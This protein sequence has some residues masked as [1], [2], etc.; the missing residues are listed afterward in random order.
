[1]PKLIDKVREQ[2]NSVLDALALSA[3]GV[4]VSFSTDTKQATVRV[5]ARRGKGFTEYT[6]PWLRDPQGT[7]L[8]DPEPFVTHVILVYTNGNSDLPRLAAAYDPAHYNST[9]E[10]V[11]RD[12]DSYVPKFHRSYIGRGGL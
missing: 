8:P 9:R 4:V 12:L 3:E 10:S 1:M 6:L 2:I 5:S 11:K 7:Y